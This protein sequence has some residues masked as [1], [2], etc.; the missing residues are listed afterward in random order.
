MKPISRVR[1][2]FAIGGL[3]IGFS[4][5]IALGSISVRNVLP[6]VSYPDPDTIQYDWP[7]TRLLSETYKD[8]DSDGTPEQW[9]I[10]LEWNNGLKG[11]QTHQDHDDDGVAE[12]VIVSA[13]DE[14][15]SITLHRSRERY[16]SPQESTSMRIENSK[17]ESHTYIDIDGNGIF[18][19]YR[20]SVTEAKYVLLNNQWYE[21]QDTSND[22]RSLEHSIRF[23]GDLKS[24]RFFQDEWVVQHD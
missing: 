16:G 9:T 11:S 22:D 18:D 7:G 23:D 12:L 13:H 21:A 1:L 20:E 5:G 17:G 15:E 14:T 19:A 3:A 10:G 2:Y 4:L 6:T 24:V 8:R